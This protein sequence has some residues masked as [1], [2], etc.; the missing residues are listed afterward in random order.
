M[1]SEPTSIP[2]KGINPKPTNNNYKV[3]LEMNNS[4]IKIQACWRGYNL[5]KE[6]KKLNDNYT[7]TILNRC[8]EKYISDLKFNNEINLL[9]SKKKEEMKISHLIYLKI[10]LNLLL[11]KNTELYHVGILIKEILFLTNRVFLDK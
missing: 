5:R 1:S 6:L 4:C 8:L 10:L 7:F 9:M 11:L 3:Y 2:T